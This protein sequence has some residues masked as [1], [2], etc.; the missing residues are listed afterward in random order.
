MNIQHARLDIFLHTREGSDTKFITSKA[1]RRFLWRGTAPIWDFL[2]FP[3]LSL[4]KANC[5]LPRAAERVLSP[6]FVFT[7]LCRRQQALGRPAGDRP[8]FKAL[9]GH[10][11][12]RG[13]P[14]APPAPRGKAAG[15]EPQATGAGPGSGTK[16][17]RAGSAAP[18]GASP[19][20]EGQG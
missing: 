3:Q 17:R 11:P 19:R 10:F 2:T 5:G 13:R 1:N 20:S 4:K 16:W 7:P 9:F 15:P 18:R 12:G 6:R 8:G 14:R